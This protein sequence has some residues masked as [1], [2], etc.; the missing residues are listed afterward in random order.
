MD[1]PSVGRIVHFYT[2]DKT[3]HFNGQGAGPYPAIVTQVWTDDMVNL[4]VLH[5]GGT[6]DEGSVSSHAGDPM[7]KRYW[8]WPPR[9]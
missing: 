1:R 9:Q 5:W 6:Y 8:E 3:K 4:K 2:D 7:G